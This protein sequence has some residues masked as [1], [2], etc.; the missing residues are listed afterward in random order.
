MYLKIHKQYLVRQYKKTAFSFGGFSPKAEHYD[1]TVPLDELKDYTITLVAHE[2]G[3]GEIALHGNYYSIDIGETVII[4]AVHTEN[5]ED[6]K[7]Y[8]RYK[9]TAVEF[10]RLYEPIGKPVVAKI[11]IYASGRT[12]RLSRVIETKITIGTVDGCWLLC[13]DCAERRR[14]DT[15]GVTILGEIQSTDITAV[16][17]ILEK[18]KEK[19]SKLR[20]ELNMLVRKREDLNRIKLDYEITFEFPYLLQIYELRNKALSDIEVKQKELEHKLEI[21]DTDFYNKLSNYYI[22]A[23]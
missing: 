22:K 6:G 16:N 12:I 17:A 10:S 2:H 9:Y 18:H 21:E 8:K 19:K 23:A 1:F 11:D 13:P 15:K 7:K 5:R 14:V 3:V 20:K 4:N